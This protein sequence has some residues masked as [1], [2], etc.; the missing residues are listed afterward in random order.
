MDLVSACFIESYLCFRLTTSE[1]K[2]ANSEGSFMKCFFYIL[3]S[4]KIFEEVLRSESRT[5]CEK[6]V[7][8]SILAT[9]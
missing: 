4:I 7:A 6:K 3:A 1:A 2:G 9:W 8:Y 5:T